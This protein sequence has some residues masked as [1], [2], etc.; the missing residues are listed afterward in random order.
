MNEQQEKR[1]NLLLT[2]YK[3]LMDE[4]KERIGRSDKIMAVGLTVL[5]AGLAHWPIWCHI[6]FGIQYNNCYDTWGT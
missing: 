4:I 6:L 5:G 2:E 3:I 1:A